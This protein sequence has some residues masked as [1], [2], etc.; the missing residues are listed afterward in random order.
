[1]LP[2]PI[3]IPKHFN[4]NDRTGQKFNFLTFEYFCGKDDLDVARWVF[5]CDCGNR[6]VISMATVVSGSTKSCGCKRKSLIS[7]ATGKHHL[8]GTPTYRSWKAIKSRCFC[9]NHTAYSRYG[10]R[11]ITMFQEWRDSFD[12]F[13]RDAGMRPSMKYTIDRI[14]NNGNYEPGNVRWITRRDQNRNKRNNVMVHLPGHGDVCLSAVSEILGINV[15]ALQRRY[16]SGIRPPRLFEKTIRFMEGWAR[17]FDK[18]LSCSDT[19]HEHRAHGL[20][21]VCYDRKRNKSKT[22]DTLN[23]TDTLT[24]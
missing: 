13:V 4:F 6:K 17:K 5:R 22:F 8:S 23:N 21:Q 20:C 14:N 1:M 2:P 24:Q 3:P 19:K 15:G 7:L 12:A 10:G 18:C 11:G 9:E 16:A